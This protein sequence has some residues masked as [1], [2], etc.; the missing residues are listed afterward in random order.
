MIWRNFNASKTT[1][2][3]IFR[4]KLPRTHVNFIFTNE[5]IKGVQNLCL[6]RTNFFR[7]L[8]WK[9]YLNWART[10]CGNNLGITLPTYHPAISYHFTSIASDPS[11]KMDACYILVLQKSYGHHFTRAGIG[12]IGQIRSLSM[13]LQFVS[14][15]F[16]VVLM[17]VFLQLHN[18]ISICKALFVQQSKGQ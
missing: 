4:V 6:L 17:A 18:F 11:P 5:A 8:S 13:N 3:L 12:L 1:E 16:Y 9:F 10:S 15:R 7:D 14:E 2:L